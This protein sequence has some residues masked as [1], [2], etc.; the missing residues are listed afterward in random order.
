MTIP[1]NQNSLTYI[2]LAFLWET[3]KQWLPQL[4][5]EDQCLQLNKYGR[6]SQL[7]Q[8]FFPL[9]KLCRQNCAIP[10]MPKEQWNKNTPLEVLRI[11][12]GEL[13]KR[14]VTTNLSVEWLSQSKKKAYSWKTKEK[15]T[16]TYISCNT[17]NRHYNSTYPG[18]E[19]SKG[20][21]KL[22]INM[23]D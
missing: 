8:G 9:W 13:K 5:Q 2:L 16:C 11:K 22:R 21:F 4:W 19:I 23:L 1:N 14:H 3:A 7:S 15:L 17:K 10:N 20:T 6:S 18:S 12:L